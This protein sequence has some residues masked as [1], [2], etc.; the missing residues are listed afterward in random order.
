MGETPLFTIR[1]MTVDDAAAVVV[2]DRKCFGKRDAW[3]RSWFVA[4]VEFCR[5]KFFVAEADDQIVGCV[6][7]EFNERNAA[8]IQTLAVDPDYHGLGIGTGLFA[9]IMDVVEARGAPLVYLEVHPGNTPAIELY[10]R[11]GFRKMMTLPDY[12]RNGDAWVMMKHYEPTV[13]SS[14][15]E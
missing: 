15:D 6:G 8:E 4:A 12:Y 3:R 11:F 9:K 13:I 5:T 1:P 2:I 10:E 7:V 14:D